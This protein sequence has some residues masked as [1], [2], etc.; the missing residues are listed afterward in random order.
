MFT[1]IQTKS[2]QTQTIGISTFSE[3]LQVHNVIGADP[4]PED[5]SVG[6]VMIIIS[7]N[8]IITIV[9]VAFIAAAMVIMIMCRQIQEQEA[10]LKVLHK[11][12]AGVKVFFPNS[13]F[14]ILSFIYIVQGLDSRHRGKTCWDRGGRWSYKK[15]LISY[16]LFQKATQ[17]LNY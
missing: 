5:E 12:Q 8:T 13:C 15:F 16:K 11:E 2:C 7:I 10:T 4:I 1:S 9:N 17:N 3:L 6:Q 14:S